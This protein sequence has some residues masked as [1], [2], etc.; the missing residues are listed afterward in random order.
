MK[1]NNVAA[2]VRYSKPLPDGAWKGVELSVEATLEPLEAWIE[3]QA[4]LYTDLGQQLRTLWTSKAS[5]NGQSTNGS[6]KAEDSTAEQSEH[7]C[8]EHLTRI[9]EVREGKSGVVRAQGWTEV[10]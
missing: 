3:A 8:Q 5:G 6:K 1:V 10:V 2:T 4:S 9:Q 7:Y